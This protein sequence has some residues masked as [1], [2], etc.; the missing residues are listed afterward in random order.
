MRQNV[1]LEEGGAVK[2]KPGVGGGPL[3]HGKGRRSLKGD[4]I[5]G[6]KIEA[7]HF[8]SITVDGKAFD[9]DILIRLSGKIKK[10]KKKLS[11]KIFGTSHIISLDEAEHLYEEGCSKLII[12]TGQYGNVKLSDE[13]QRFF[14]ARDVRCI[15]Q[16]TGDAIT[17]YNHENGAK[18]GL[19][20]V[21]C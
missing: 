3:I 14:E 2:M 1:A 13:A 10:R 19:F 7:T 20:H 17:T 4:E 16:P 8:G 5:M 18:L 12:G 11:K 6:P 9:H 21:T 15:L